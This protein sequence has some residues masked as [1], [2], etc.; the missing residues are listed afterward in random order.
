MNNSES[1]QKL[2]EKLHALRKQRGITVIELGDMLGVNN[3]HIVRIEKGYRK[4]SLE[5]VL[6]I[7]RIFDVPIDVLVK[8]EL[9]LK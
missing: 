3:S 7:S 8:D 5:L 2:G 6:Q 4:P 1:I 9:E